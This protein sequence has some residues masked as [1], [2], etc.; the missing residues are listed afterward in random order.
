M[1][2]PKDNRSDNLDLRKIQM[3]RNSVA[4]LGSNESLSPFDDSNH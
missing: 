3:K 4:P 2:S 1:N